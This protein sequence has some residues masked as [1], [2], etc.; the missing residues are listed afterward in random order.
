MTILI[1]WS[2]PTRAPRPS[3]TPRTGFR[4]STISGSAMRSPPAAR[5]ATTTRRWASRRAAPG[6]RCGVI[7]ARWMSTSRRRRSR[8]RASATCRATCSATACCASAPSSWSRR[9]IIAT[10][11]SIRR[12]IRSAASPS[13]SACSICSRSSWQD[14]DKELS[15]GGRRHLFAQGQGNRAQRRGAGVAR[16]STE[17]VTPQ[18]VMT[19][20]LKAQHRSPVVRRHRHLH[21]RLERNR[22]SGRRPRQRSDPH[23]RRELVRAKVVGEGANLGMTQRG[24]VEA[25]QRGVRI[26]TDAIDNSAGVNTSDVEVNIKI[27]LSPPMRD[28]RL[29]LEARDN[30]A[31][32]NDRRG[33]PRWC[34]ATTTSRRWRSR[35]RSGAGWRIWASSS[36]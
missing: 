23:H 33:R 36:G 26:N 18:Q 13:G 10:S 7:S 34:C 14:Y 11:S 30:A 19:A 32:R 9:S 15:L 4:S 31:R 27:A 20:I 35:W 2:R 29:S 28:G 24:R 5:P 12:P 17:K 3:P 22:R 25:A 16:A 8:S 6:R 21:P 1:S